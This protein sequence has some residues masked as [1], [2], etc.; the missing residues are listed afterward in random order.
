MTAGLETFAKVRA[1]HDGTTSAGEKAAA[2]GRMEVLARSLGMTVDEA[3]SKLNT[4]AAPP[5]S[6]VDWAAFAEAFRKAERWK[7]ERTK[8]TVV[9]PPD[10]SSRRRGLPIYD[11]NKIEPWR[12]V[13]EHCL[14]LDWI[15]PKAHGGRF[16]TKAE[17]ER[18]KVIA[19]HY[20][21]V[22]NAIADWIETVLA[23]CDVAR[24]SWRDRGK[25]GVRP[26][27]KAIESDIEKAAE[28]VAA[29][30]R[31]EASKLDT[32]EPEPEPRSQA[33]SSADSLN[34]FFNRPEFVA[35]RAEQDRKRDA[36][37]AEILARYGSVEAVYA[38]TE[39]EAALRGACETMTVWDCRPD[40][41]GN[42]TLDGWGC[43]SRREEVP[44][45]VRAAVSAAWPLPPTL[46][47]AWA[48]FIAAEEHESDRQTMHDGEHFP[49]LWAE[50]RRYLVEDLL[51][52]LP[53]ASIAD[54]LMRQS[55]LEHLNEQ[56]FSRSIERDA[57]LLASLRAD[58]ERMAVQFG[59]PAKAEAQA[60][61]PRPAPV[62]SG[63]ADEGSQ[64]AYPARRTTADKRRDVLAL[65]AAGRPDGGPLTDRE[66]ARRAGVS[67]TTVGAIR[68]AAGEVGR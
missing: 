17:R 55:W 23:R 43:L 3:L 13:A 32:S 41:E 45:R 68:R 24:A 2:A 36:R 1:L 50:V 33:Q 35:K 52:T 31:R 18:L 28:L 39:R 59:R 38:E 48:E 42:Y 53:A 16:L 51:D 21:L 27:R 61:S 63:Q 67:P 22:T 15:I 37:R 58:I 8:S 7:A 62:Q 4:A 65:L 60:A 12:D 26:D 20:S 14:Q 54:M 5:V 56:G 11:P 44:S 57:I 40:R 46:T 10:A 64:P 47:E 34:A 9:D 19:R 49:E 25:A 66:I 6:D 30:K 29:A